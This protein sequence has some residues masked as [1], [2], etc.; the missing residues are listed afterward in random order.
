[1]GGGVGSWLQLSWAAPRLVRRVVVHDRPND[2]DGITSAILSFS[3]GSSVDVP[4]FDDPGPTVIAF[5]PRIVTWLILTV[6]GVTPTTRNTGLA[7]I[8]VEGS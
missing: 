3:D 1:M 6:T 2:D 8:Q 5:A 7:E 4:D